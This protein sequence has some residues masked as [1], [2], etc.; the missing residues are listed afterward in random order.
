METT[1][2]PIINVFDN[3]V[4]ESLFDTG[5]RYSPIVL[6]SP[7]AAAL[8]LDRMAWYGE[9]LDRCEPDACADGEGG[10]GF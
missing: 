5:Q 1:G 4:R 10:H 7:G 2:K 6:A 9:Y 8:V 3:P